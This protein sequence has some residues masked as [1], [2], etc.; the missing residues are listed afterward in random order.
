MSRKV[1]SQTCPT[2]TVS[3]NPGWRKSN[4]AAAG[5]ASS[6]SSQHDINWPWGNVVKRC[7]VGRSANELRVKRNNAEDRSRRDFEDG[8]QAN[9]MAR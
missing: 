6:S 8:V 5:I 7:S 9:S 1:I 2:S 3:F 4:S